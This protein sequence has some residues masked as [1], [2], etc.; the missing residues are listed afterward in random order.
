MQVIHLPV[1][2]ASLLTIHCWRSSSHSYLRIFGD[3]GVTL[4]HPFVVA[5]HNWSARLRSLGEF[6]SHEWIATRGRCL[7]WW[8]I[9][10]FKYEFTSFEVHVGIQKSSNF[11]HASL[12][13]NTN[14]L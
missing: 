7:S 9:N 10:K 14:V 12:Y 13:K 3:D 8:R 4:N 6:R 11:E 1:D 2:V 5:T